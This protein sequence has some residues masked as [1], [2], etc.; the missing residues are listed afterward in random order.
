M[1]E[2]HLD[3]EVGVRLSERSLLACFSPT[4]DSWAKANKTYTCTYN[5]CLYAFK[6]LTIFIFPHFT[7]SFTTLFVVICFYSFLQ[8]FA[9]LSPSISPLHLSLTALLSYPPLHQSFRSLLHK[10]CCLEL[11]SRSNTYC[12]GC[13]SPPETRSWIPGSTSCFAGRFSRE[14]TLDLTGP[15]APSWPCTHPSETPCAG[16]HVL[17]SLALWDRMKRE[18]WGN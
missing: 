18:R 15:G 12:C 14:S 7:S 13:A 11:H 17:Q 1:F 2:R 3:L 5:M 16:W 4:W 8:L 9:F 10:L 6:T